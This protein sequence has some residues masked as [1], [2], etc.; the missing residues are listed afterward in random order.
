MKSYDSR[1]TQYFPVYT[2]DFYTFIFFRAVK[3]LS[4]YRNVGWESLAPFLRLHLFRFQPPP[5]TSFSLPT[6]FLRRFSPSKLF[7]D[8]QILSLI[9]CFKGLIFF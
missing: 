3:V 4:R 9:Y 8:F 2:V 7:I 1:N 5:T 6:P